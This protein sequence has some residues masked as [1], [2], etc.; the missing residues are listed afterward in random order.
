MHRTH[1][2]LSENVLT[3]TAQT[4]NS[5]PA[6]AM[7]LHG[8]LTGALECTGSLLRRRARTVQQGRRRSGEPLRPDRRTGRGPRRGYGGHVQGATERSFLVPCPPRI[9]TKMDTCS[10]LRRRLPPSGN[11]RAMRSVR[12]L[13][14]ATPIRPISSPKSGE[15]ST[16][17]LGSSNLL[18]RQDERSSGPRKGSVR[19]SL[20]APDNFAADSPAPG[21]GVAAIG[22]GTVAEQRRS[23]WE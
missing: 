13:R 4:L 10:Q 2:T 1:N 23:P 11:R 22:S 18:P 17:S 19:R 20:S 21:S 5:R 7:D 3:Q 12:P 8:Q 15:A 16:I 14:A 6:P 9:A